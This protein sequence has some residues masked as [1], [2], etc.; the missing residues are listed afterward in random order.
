MPPTSL[1]GLVSQEAM[2]S[3]SRPVRDWEPIT[4]QFFLPLS[5]AKMPHV[6][7]YLTPPTIAQILSLIEHT[8][9]T[10]VHTTETDVVLRTSSTSL[11]QAK[12][13]TSPS[14]ISQE[15]TPASIKSRPNVELLLSLLTLPV[16]WLSNSLRSE[17]LS[18]MVQLPMS[19]AKIQMIL[20]RNK[21]FPSVVSHPE[22][23]IS[24]DLQ[25]AKVGEEISLAKAE[26]QRPLVMMTRMLMCT[27]RSG[28]SMTQIAKTECC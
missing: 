4:L 18:W 15:V 16:M 28:T 23:Q 24:Q 11:K 13:L 8:P 25:M 6:L 3:A 12:L 27:L 17:D 7:K 5:V 10:C 26:I 19:M 14:P 1:V 2:S 9:S 21:L 22:I 20:S